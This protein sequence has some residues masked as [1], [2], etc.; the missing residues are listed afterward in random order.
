MAGATFRVTNPEAPRRAADPGIG[1]IADR[2]KGDVVAATPVLT[3]RLAAGWQIIKDHEGERRVVNA[4]P[5]AKYVE[6]GTRYMSPEP[7]IGPVMARYR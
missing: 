7:M 6:Y 2:I 5:Y 3:G 1:G 4:V